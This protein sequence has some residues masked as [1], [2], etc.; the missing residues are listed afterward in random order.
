MTICF[1]CDKSVVVTVNNH[2]GIAGI[3]LKDGWICL[4]CANKI[5][6]VKNSVVVE[7]V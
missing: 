5:T 6:D 1:L 2:T 4:D 3:K 7:D